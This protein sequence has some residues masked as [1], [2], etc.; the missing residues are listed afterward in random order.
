MWKNEDGVTG[1]GN[2]DTGVKVGN[3]ER[4]KAEEWTPEEEGKAK[5]FKEDAR[6]G[7]EEKRGNAKKRRNWE[8][9]SKV[10][11][12]RNETRSR[13]GRHQSCSGDIKA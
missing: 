4:K 2:R 13:N 7:E 1:G 12:R 10:E 3:E 9:Q 5:K 11:K 8:H 6:M